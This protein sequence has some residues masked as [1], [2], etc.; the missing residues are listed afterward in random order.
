[1]KI[2][3]TLCPVTDS[4]VFLPGVIMWPPRSRIVVLKEEETYLYSAAGSDACQVLLI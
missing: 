4:G 3:A 2:S 1:M